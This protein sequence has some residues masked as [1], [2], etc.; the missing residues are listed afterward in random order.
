MAKRQGSG[1][2]RKKPAADMD[3]PAVRGI[4][5]NAR[6]VTERHEAEDQLRRMNEDLDLRVRDRTKAIEILYDIAS[7][8]NR[9]QDVRQALEYCLRRLTEFNGWRFG[10][11]LLPTAS[12]SQGLLL[13]SS[14]YP[15]G[16]E[17]FAAFREATE[18][19]TF[20]LG[21]GLPGK[22]LRKRQTVWTTRI[23]Q[24]LCSARA[25]LA[26][27]LGLG[28]AVAFPVRVGEKVAAVLEFFSTHVLP[29]D[30]RV[31][32][33]MDSVGMQLGRVFERVALQEHLLRIADQT[34]QRIAQ[35]LH[36]D[37]GQEL[38]GLGLKAETLAESLRADDTPLGRLAADVMNAVERARAKVRSLARRVLPIE[39]ELNS[40]GGA[41]ARLAE[42]T[43]C[44]SRVACTFHNA[45][46]E[47]TFDGR[48]AAQL[49]RIAQESVAN[50][51]C[52]GQA[53]NIRIELTDEDGRTR[54]QIVD[55]GRGLPADADKVDGLGL[56]IM[57]Y[58]AGLLGGK[59]EVQPGARGGTSIVCLLPAA[60]SGT[61]VSKVSKRKGKRC[62]PPKS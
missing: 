12:D 42:E 37:L 23:S 28:T 54:L 55:D 5:L 6:D 59:L 17:G 31:R 21:E 46:P 44:G 11:A 53:R 2:Q 20:H 18:Q 39:I 30:E 56:R 45:H 43:T 24:E 29:P 32:V 19:V 47:S 7:V 58:R 48:I 34:Q 49:Y 16:T 27:E 4:V 25:E 61:M 33:L 60:A 10:H 9:A 14:W 35:D 52:H 51:I 50:A 62:P 22:V 36:D 3:E 15:P 57:R 13:A 26:E 41:M 1:R 8:A 40:L 38:T